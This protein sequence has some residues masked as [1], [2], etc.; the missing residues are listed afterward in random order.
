MIVIN[1]TTDLPIG[2]CLHAKI[3][4]SDGTSKDYQAWKEWL[5]RRDRKPLET[6]AFLIVDAAVSEA[7][8]GAMVTL[9]V[10]YT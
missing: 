3:H 6:E 5:R 4:L 7:P 1:K 2:H 9:D 8:T 10:S